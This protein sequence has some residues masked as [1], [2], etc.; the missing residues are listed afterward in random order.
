MLS[1]YQFILK[2]TSIG[3]FRKIY[4]KL[5]DENLINISTLLFAICKSGNDDINVR[6]WQI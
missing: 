1:C 2:E 4:N 5:L 6:S 3:F